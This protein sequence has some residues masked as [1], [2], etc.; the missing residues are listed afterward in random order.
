MR[1]VVLTSLMGEYTDIPVQDYRPVVVYLN[2]KYWGLHYFREKLNENYVA[3]HFNVPAETVTVV[4]GAGWLSPEYRALVSFVLKND[5]SVE[6]NYAY[7]CSQMDVDSYIDMII[8]QIWCANTDNG[9]IRFYRIDDGKWTWFFFDT[10]LAL[11]NAEL[12]TI[13]S[14]LTLAGLD[15]TD[16]ACRTFVAKMMSHDEFREKFLTRLAWQMN[17][18]WTEENVLGRI[19]EIE[20]IIQ[21]IM[22][23]ECE[24]WDANY[25]NWEIHLDMMKNFASDRNQYLLTYIQE[26]FGFTAE[27]MR[28]YGFNV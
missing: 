17:T 5:M 18:I 23:R 13:Y 25:R 6:E 15:T 3:G 2:G 11:R 8:A 12:N 16:I 7:V 4:E 26:F 24:T 21:P 19:N 28:A 10:D 9:N 1:D 27:E 22:V 20:T 14:Y